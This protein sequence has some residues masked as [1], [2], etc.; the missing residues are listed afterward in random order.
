M[1]NQVQNVPYIIHCLIQ[2]VKENMNFLCK[3]RNFGHIVSDN[4]NY[5]KVLEE[6]ET[7]VTEDSKSKRKNIFKQL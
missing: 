5:F 6:I 7:N 4:L 1:M 2:Y 3:C